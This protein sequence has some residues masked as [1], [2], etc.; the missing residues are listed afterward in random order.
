MTRKHFIQFANE[1]K[2][3]VRQGKFREA[4]AA[5]AMVVNVGFTANPNFDKNKFLKA[6]ALNA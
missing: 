6:C 3:L 5:A 2:N 1:I 4:E